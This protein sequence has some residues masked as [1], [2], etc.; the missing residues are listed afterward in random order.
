MSNEFILIVAWKPMKR[1]M[2]STVKHRI[3][4]LNIDNAGMLIESTVDVGDVV[5]LD[6][7]DS[8]FFKK[9][10]FERKDSR[11]S[12]RFMLKSRLGRI[13]DIS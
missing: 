5:I 8:I 2:A 3:D 11:N 7:A 1:L 13:S 12:S 10:V 6:I 4:S 9:Y